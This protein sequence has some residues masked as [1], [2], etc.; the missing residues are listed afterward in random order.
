[1]TRKNLTIFFLF[2]IIGSTILFVVKGLMITDISLSDECHQIATAYRFWQGDSPLVDDWSSEQLHGLVLLPVLS[3]FL[4]FT[5]STEGVVLY[6]RIVYLLLKFVVAIW[7]FYKLKNKNNIMNIL[8]G[9][10]LW[11]FFSPY[12]IDTLTYQAMPLIMLMIA[13]VILYAEEPK[14]WECIV[15]GAVYALSVLSQPF[16]VISYIPILVFLFLKRTT[17]KKFLLFFHIGIGT[18]FILFCAVVLINSS[19]TEII[20]NIIFIIEEQDHDLSGLGLYGILYQ[21]VWLVFITLIRE[22]KFVS[23]IN[24]LYICILACAKTYRERLKIGMPIC[25]SLS[26][27]SMFFLKKPFLMNEFFIPFIW[28]GVENMLFVL[29]KCKY[30]QLFFLGILFSIAIAL[31]TNTGKLA[32]SASLCILAVIV[33][34]FGDYEGLSKKEKNFNNCLMFTVL[35]LG[36]GLRIIITWG[37]GNNSCML[38]I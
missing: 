22:N 2:A 21:K 1:M 27:I 37:G 24:L 25:L 34:F 33:L 35:L 19:V 16:W 36:L 9:I 13:V 29:K 15:S 6:L 32:T 8:F 4:A 7:A 3:P 30:M 12:N 11:Y 14:P 28:M 17:M 38:R 26:I 20:D 18:I 10:L 31:G 23:V 5:K